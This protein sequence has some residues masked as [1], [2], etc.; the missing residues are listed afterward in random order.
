MQVNVSAWAA[1]SVWIVAGSAGAQ[2]AD[3]LALRRQV[4]QATFAPAFEQA[5]RAP[6]ER[7][8]DQFPADLVD[9][10]ELA[11]GRAA[12]IRETNALVERFSAQAAEVVVRR[13]PLAELGADGDINS[14][15]WQAALAEIDTLT[16]GLQIEA[17]DA[18]T[19][20]IRAACTVKRE[21]SQGCAAM[22]SL[23][24]IQAARP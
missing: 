21:P 22:L 19:R 15:N 5:M 20:V 4:V 12:H 6:I 13:V 18:A 11:A 24:D 1:L 8:W 9:P 10:E 7:S 23:P 3:D 17:E 14:P 16:Q 2:S